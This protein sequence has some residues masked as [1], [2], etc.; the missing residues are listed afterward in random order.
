MKKK[1][2]HRLTI[3]AVSVAAGTGALIWTA[4]LAAPHDSVNDAAVATWS[5]Q[6]LVELIAW[7]AAEK[8]ALFRS[9]A[10]VW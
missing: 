1:T 4:S 2:F 8:D 6:S 3:A 7:D 10:G 5:R 9:F